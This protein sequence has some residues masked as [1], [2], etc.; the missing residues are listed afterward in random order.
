MGICT[1]T[2]K[3]L[4]REVMVDMDKQKEA[5]LVYLVFSIVGVGLII[6]A[7]VS[8]IVHINFKKQAVEITGKVSKIETYTDSDNE[9]NHRVYVDYSINGK[10]YED[11]PINF[12]SSSMREGG[13][14][15]LLCNADTGKVRS[16]SAGIVVFIVLL[17]MGLVFLLGGIIPLL[18]ALKNKNVNGNTGSI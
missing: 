15:E 14:I 7:I 12:Y 1:R 3:T 11:V 18:L 17:F 9:T 5:K 4:N 10:S 8:L 16:K 6:G 13:A 2:A